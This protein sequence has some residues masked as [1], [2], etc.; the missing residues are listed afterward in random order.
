M[1]TFAKVA[2]VADIE[3]GSAGLVQV[4][5]ADIAIFNAGGA[6]YAIQDCCTGDGGSLSRG[7]LIGTMVECPSDS[8][9]FYLPTGECV[10]PRDLCGLATC[11]IWVDE[12]DIKLHL[13][14]A[15]TIARAPYDSIAAGEFSSP[16]R[17][18]MPT[19]LEMSQ[20]GKSYDTAQARAVIIKNFNLCVA[21]AEF[22]CLIGHSGCG[23]STVLS[24]AMGLNEAT[25]GG[26]ILTGKEVV[27]P[28]LDRGVVFQSPALLPW[29]TARENVLLAVEQV[30]QRR[31]R[32]ENREIADK[33]LALVGLTDIAGCYPDELSAGMRQRVGIA[34]AFALEPKV[35]LL[36]EPFS[37]LDV[38]TRMELQDELMRLWETERKT[39]LMVTHD[40][41][42]ALLLADRIVLM[43]NGPAATVGEIV[44]VPFERP[45]DR[46]R[47]A[48]DSRYDRV[49]NRLLTFLEEGADQSHA[50]SSALEQRRE[51]KAPLGSASEDLFIMEKY[52]GFN[53]FRQKYRKRQCMGEVSDRQTGMDAK[54]IEPVN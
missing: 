38:I 50:R 54:L 25:E 10:G 51:K 24:I 37:L 33:Y 31:R 11:R 3:Q 20:L 35:L 36:D 14:E 44:A 39:V 41:D 13:R 28:G 43:T 29:M 2:H 52:T 7:K 49:R 40:V 32:K 9:R 17:E 45:R 1:E 23:K 4:Q 19:F 53:R 16:K 46:L 26:V 42:E 27:G 6:F 30:N 48:D 22:V 47:L 12:D 34:R 18:P 8:A 15:A 5:G 21:E